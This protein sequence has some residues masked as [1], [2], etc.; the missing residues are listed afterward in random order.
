MGQ[1]WGQGF[2]MNNL[3]I[4]SLLISLGSCRWATDLTALSLSATWWSFIWVLP[5]RAVVRLKQL[6]RGSALGTLDIYQKKKNDIRGSAV[7]F[8]SCWDLQQIKLW[9]GDNQ[10]PAPR[11][12]VIRAAFPN[13]VP[14]SCFRLQN[15]SAPIGLANGRWEL[16][17]F[18]G[19]D[20]ERDSFGSHFDANLS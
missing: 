18:G 16:E 7:Q 9:L 3:N 10:I 15:P 5:W 12:Y 14:S 4:S 19:G 1:D 8:C 6:W 11:F 2:N 20:E 17:S 13:L